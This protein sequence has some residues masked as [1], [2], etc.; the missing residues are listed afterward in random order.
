[1]KTPSSGGQHT[2]NLLGHTRCTG[3]TI[4]RL[5]TSH[6]SA[7]ARS[8]CSSRGRGRGSGTWVVASTR[9][10]FARSRRGRGKGFGND[11]TV[12]R[13]IAAPPRVPRGYS[14]DRGDP[15]SGL[16]LACS[17]LRGGIPWRSSAEAGAVATTWIFRGGGDGRKTGDVGAADS[18]LS[19]RHAAVP[20]L[21]CCRD[22]RCTIRISPWPCASWCL[23]AG[24]V[25]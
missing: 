14:E 19:S 25:G 1:M 7:S 17:Y 18:A 9:E 5:Y 10:R 6:D 2:Q 11:A 24:A 20:S 23:T 3:E 16:G 4:T 22:Q 8:W 15:P 13:R 21:F 12:E